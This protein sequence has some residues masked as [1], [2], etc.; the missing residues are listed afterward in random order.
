MEPGSIFD[1][2]N[3][4]QR[5]AVEAVRGPVC[6]LAGAGSGKTTTITRR[7]ANQVATDTFGPTEILAVTFTDKA[8]TEMRERLAG[9]RAAGVPARTFHSA[10]L[11]QL[12]YFS[13]DGVGEILSS[14]ALLLKQISR[15]L[16]VPFRFRPVGDLATEVEWAK[17]RRLTPATYLDGLDGH[18]P[19]IPEDLMLRV[20]RE[21]ERRKEARGRIDFEDVLELAVRLFDQDPQAVETFRARYRAFTVDEYQD[22]NM[23]QQSLL[24]RWLGDRDDLCAV[25]DDYQSI[26]SFTGATPDHLLAMPERFPRATVVRLEENY[27]STPEILETANGLVPRLAGARKVLRA[28]RPSGGEPVVRAFANLP[29]ELE[30]LVARITVLRD[31]SVPYEELAVLYR[32]NA[33]SE[34]YEEALSLAGI[35]YQVRGGAF[36]ARPAARATLRLLRRASG[37]R[38]A[39]GVRAAADAQGFTESVP[40]DVGN[41]ETTRQSDLARLVRLAEEFDD[42]TS[43]VADFVAD[44][45]ARFGGEAQSRGVNLLTYHRAKGLEF[46]AVFLPNL[47]EGELPFKRADVEEER[48]LFYVGMTRAKRHLELTWSGKP[49]RFLRELGALREPE[50][51]GDD[52]PVF[53]ALK[54]WRRERAKEDGIPAFV[55]FHDKTLEEIARRRPG[56]LA[57]LGAVSGVGP[58]K[59]ERYGGDVLDALAGAR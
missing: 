7:I 37:S 38:A 23:L 36:L 49:S 1:R 18:E 39:E 44:L 26:Y 54:T 17:N 27:R 16:P 14:K 19:P 6:I 12:H 35:P 57:A 59:L 5:R 32:I 28:V 51:V 24:E 9:L 13:R 2:L 15:S 52:D 10:A 47:V 33:R 42:G 56:D 41:E 45:Q 43:T 48:R 3:P 22:V 53:K 31:E 34:D 20:F 21:Y 55:V 29:A 58:A 25:G 50:P 30:A 46:E 8:A 11:A 4:E 40:D